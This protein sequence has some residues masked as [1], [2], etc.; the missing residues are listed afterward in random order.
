VAGFPLG[1]STTASKAF[2]AG[3][4]AALGAREV[5]MVLAVWAI[6]DRQYQIAQA[7]ISAV[8]KAAGPGCGVKVI[9]ETCLLSNEEKITACRL[10]SDAG[11]SFVKTSTGLAGAGATVADIR[12]MRAAVGPEM[13]VKAS[14]GI[15]TRGEA[16]AMVE[17]GANRIGTSA[18]ITIVTHS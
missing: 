14:G 12:L 10:A 13:G 17:A 18:G 9:F 4:A 15:R 11:A 3:E 6:R 5:D 16:L 7:D 8:V 2:E 1:A